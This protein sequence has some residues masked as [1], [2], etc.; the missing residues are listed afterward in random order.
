M[1][2]SLLKADPQPPYH[3]GV[4]STRHHA[5]L[6]PDLQVVCDEVILH[7]DFSIL[8]GFRNRVEQRNVLA[9][10]FTQ[11]DWPHS[12]HNVM[13]SAAMDIA[14]Y[15]GGIDWKDIKGFHHFAG[16]VLATADMLYAQGKISHRLRWGGNF[17][18]FFDGVHFELI[19]N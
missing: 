11:V 18:S 15:N 5:T 1:T 17:K 7:V 2:T 19:P 9:M 13:P 4:T 10:G 16:R 12:K 3:F 6:H 8:G 14:P